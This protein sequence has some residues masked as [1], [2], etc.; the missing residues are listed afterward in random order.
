MIVVTNILNDMNLS[1]EGLGDNLHLHFGPELQGIRYRLNDCGENLTVE[2]D[3][4]CRKGGLVVARHKDV[5]DE[6]EA[7]SKAA[8]TPKNVSH[9]TLIIY[10]GKLFFGEGTRE[11]HSGHQLGIRGGEDS[12]VDRKTYWKCRWVGLGG[13]SSGYLK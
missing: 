4:Q 6:L 11:D 8:L 1:D 3:M 9:K 10:G 7:L 13:D 2:H 5:S 12:R